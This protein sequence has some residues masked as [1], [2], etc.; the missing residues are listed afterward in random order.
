MPRTRKNSSDCFCYICGEYILKTQRH[1]MIDLVKTAY[2]LYFGFSID[3][4][5]KGWLPKVYSCSR[6]LRGWLEESHKSMPFS[7]PMIWSEPQNHEN[8]CYF[9]TTSTRGFSKKNRALKSRALSQYT[10]APAPPLP[11][12]LHEADNVTMSL[13]LVEGPRDVTVARGQDAVFRCVAHSSQGRPTVTWYHEGR[14]LP[15]EGDR[16][17]AETAELPSEN[18]RWLAVA[19][20][21][22][23]PRVTG[24]KRAADGAAGN[25]SCLV[26]NDV[27]ALL[28]GT[29]RLR[30]ASI[31]KE[32]LVSD[33]KTVYESQPLLLQ[34]SIHSTPPAGLGWE[35]DQLPLPKDERYVPLPNGTLLIRST[36]LSDSGNYRC[37]AENE[38]LNKTKVSRKVAVQVLPRLKSSVGP[39][40]PRSD[41]PLN[42]TVLIGDTVDF[43]CVATGF[44][45]PTVQWFTGDN[46]FLANSSNLTITNANPASAGAYKCVASNSEGQT[47]Q[48]YHLDVY[49]KP[50]FNVTPSSKSS[51]S[52][53]TIRLDCQAR[54]VPQPRVYWL[55]DG[56]PINIGGRIKKQWSGLIFSHTFTYDSGIYQC[57]AVNAVGKAWTAAQIKINKSQN[58]NPPENV[59]CRPFDSGTVCLTWRNP[60]NVTVQAYSISSFLSDD[61][62]EGPDYVTTNT[63]QLA[64]GLRDGTNYTFY[65]RLYSTV[66][67]DQS[68]RVTCSTGVKGSRNLD[69]EAVTGTSVSLEWD[70]LS[71]DTLCNGTRQF[72]KVYWRKDGEELESVGKTL[73]RKYVITGL[74][75]STDYQ[76]RVTTENNPREEQW[77]TYRLADA[78]GNGTDVEDDVLGAPLHL[79]GDASS[80]SSVRLSWDTMPNA[81]Y[82]SV[83]YWMV[84]EKSDCKRN[85]F[86]KS[87]SWKLT[88]SKLKSNTRYAFRVRAHDFNNVPGKFSEPVEVRTLADVP[89]S[90]LNLQYKTIN[91]SAACISWWPPERRNGELRNYVVSY[92]PDPNWPLEKWVEFGVPLRP[93]KTQ[94]CGDEGSVSTIL[95]NLSTGYEYMLMVRAANDFGIGKPVLPVIIKT[96]PD[97]DDNKSNMTEQ[98][99]AFTNHKIGV[100]LGVILALVCILACVVMIFLRKRCLKRRALGHG[101][102]TVSSNYHP[103]AAHYTSQLGSVQVRMEEPCT[104]ES[105]EIERLVP[106]DRS[107]SHIPPEVPEHL[108]TKGTQDFPNGHLNGCHKPARHQNG[109]IPNGLVNI[110]ENPQYYATE[111]D[112]KKDSGS[113]LDRYE[114]DSNSNV[115]SSKFWDLYRFFESP[116]AKDDPLNA[117]TLTSLDDSLLSRQRSSP[118]LEPNG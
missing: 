61:E 37:V 74:T 62:S 84:G 44:P 1:F 46:V 5:D 36:K 53:K 55:K 10:P 19:A 43:V 38:L 101:R 91:A 60:S 52:A 89:S 25:Y 77:L 80:S 68:E 13:L 96:N 72:Y 22:R 97:L 76:F 15:P 106:E 30:V 66:A 48:T 90:V 95:T 33:N 114:E 70:Q 16:W 56:E 79:Q 8:D 73:D 24:G 82:Y 47:S 2:K 39:A 26:K 108:D 88:M 12:S 110:T 28:S 17:N 42:R 64:D 103:A 112:V 87:Y 92:S 117:T 104:T 6:T 100:I 45:L 94:K 65:V 71:S 14:P 83:C 50:Y 102:L 69:A 98:A 54:G 41:S 9:C 115:K 3:E 27:G 23:V 58:P 86:V 113:L 29:A 67:S 57:V 99:A 7:M 116:K 85:D 34:C 107:S 11:G 32:V 105:H 20:V 35:H 118:I 4:R 78:P 109:N 111:R 63:Y 49:Q 40:F 51:P 59:K 31:D 75:P 18:D 21:L 93:I 81:K